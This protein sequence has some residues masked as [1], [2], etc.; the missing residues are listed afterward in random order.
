MNAKAGF[1][2]GWIVA[3]VCGFGLACGISVFIPSTLGLLAGPLSAELG[4]TQPQVFQAP[5]WATVTTVVI[6]PSLGRLIDRIGARRVIIASFI[7][8][9]IILASFYWIDRAPLPFYLRYTALAAL[10]TGNTGL[11]F[12]KVIGDWFDRRRGTALGVTLA[13]VGVGG[14]AWT[15]AAQ[16]LFDLVG[17]RLTFP[18]LAVFLLLVVTPVMALAIRNRPADMGLHV[19]GDATAQRDAESRHGPS[20][21]EA[22]RA[23]PYWMLLAVAFLVGFGIQALMLHLVPLLKESGYSP[24]VAA[25]AQ[26]SLWMA[27]VLGRLST[28]WLMDRFPAPRIAALF[29]CFPLVAIFLLSTSTGGA[30]GFV[31]AMLIGLA[32]GAEV[33]VIAFL[34][35]RY[36]GL[37]HYG[38]I[39]STFFSAFVIGSGTGPLV[40]SQLHEQAGGHYTQALYAMGAVLLAAAVMFLF[41]KRTPAVT[42]AGCTP[43]PARRK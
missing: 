20:L 15:L 19:D 22:G 30:G 41:L 1:F 2:H 26:A 21:R 35:T 17:W 6:A 43:P 5:V 42:H 11:A 12:T 8:Q 34:T 16:H 3:L 24:Q 18:L 33:D 37:R 32:S 25:N 7:I 31:A 10:A 36:F 39:Y 40:A 27:L 9:A 14:V 38:A 23:H 4:W 28:G 29:L 13:G